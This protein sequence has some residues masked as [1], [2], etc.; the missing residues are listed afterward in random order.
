MATL[1][2]GPGSGFAHESLAIDT[3]SGGVP[4]TASKYD[5]V[6]TA[7]GITTT[8]HANR[9]V[10]TVEDQSLRWTV[11]GTAAS[12]TVGHLAA[13]GDVFQVEGYESIVKF[14]AR[15]S[16]GTNSNIRVTYFRTD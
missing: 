15:R 16:G 10:I 4:L 8:R 5:A 14:R 3:T 2:I 7:N 1:T 13:A 9:A 12:D 11:D 6:L